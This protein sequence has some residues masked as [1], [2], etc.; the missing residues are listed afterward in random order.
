LPSKAASLC[1]SVR[2]CLGFRRVGSPALP[3]ALEGL[4]HLGVE[5][6]SVDM[7]SLTILD[8]L[9]PVNKP[10]RHELEWVL[11]DGNNLVD[12]LR[13]EL[14]SAAKWEGR[15]SEE[16]V[17]E[18]SIRCSPKI[19]KPFDTSRALDTGSSSRWRE[20]E[21]RELGAGGERMKQK[22]SASREGR[23]TKQIERCVK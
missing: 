17:E 21:K 15:I 14:A 4:A 12:L 11:D 18:A 9:L 23:G 20:W 2:V 19:L 10:R 16:L 5:Q 7:G 1:L 3:E 8:V 13:G 22:D 6:V